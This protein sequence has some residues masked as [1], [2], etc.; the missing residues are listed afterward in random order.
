MNEQGFGRW[1]GEVFAWMLT[2]Y[3]VVRIVE[4]S[5][6]TDEPGRFGTRLSISQWISI[7]LSAATAVFWAWLVRQPRGSVLPPPVD[8]TP[9]AG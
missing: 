4:E 7:E 2:L 5:L 6:R 8:A 1:D 3:P 9:P